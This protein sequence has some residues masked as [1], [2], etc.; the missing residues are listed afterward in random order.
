MIWTGL[1][2]FERH[3]LCQASCSRT[4]KE[5]CFGPT[6]HISLEWSPPLAEKDGYIPNNLQWLHFAV[7]SAFVDILRL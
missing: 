6:L 5:R 2:L 4:D 7:A 1:L 3:D